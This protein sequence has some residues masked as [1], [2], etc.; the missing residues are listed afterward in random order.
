MFLTVEFHHVW[1]VQDCVIDGVHTVALLPCTDDLTLP[2]VLVVFG[3]QLLILC[4]RCLKIMNGRLNAFV[5][6]LLL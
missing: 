6:N 1:H 2:G 5:I 4:W 3:G